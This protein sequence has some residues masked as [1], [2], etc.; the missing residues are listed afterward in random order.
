MAWPLLARQN[1]CPDEYE[2]LYD[3]TWDDEANAKDECRQ[4]PLHLGYD[5]DKLSFRQR[6][7][8]I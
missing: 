8:R 4:R 7:Q 6:S 2:D 3:E 1:Q 5:T